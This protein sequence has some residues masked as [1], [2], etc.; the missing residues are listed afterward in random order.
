M[1]IPYHKFNF[2]GEKTK[3]HLSHGAAQ[4]HLLSSTFFFHVVHCV[5][6]AMNLSVHLKCQYDSLKRFCGDLFV[7]YISYM[8]FCRSCMMTYAAVMTGSSNSLWNAHE[9]LLND[10][11]TF[12]SWR[13]NV[14][15]CPH[16]AA[17]LDVCVR[18]IS[19]PSSKVRSAVETQARPWGTVPKSTVPKRTVP[20]S[21]NE[22]KN[23]IQKHHRAR[24]RRNCL[25]SRGTAPLLC[26]GEELTCTCRSLPLVAWHWNQHSEPWGD[27]RLHYYEEQTALQQT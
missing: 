11:V 27:T 4:M 13:K 8:Y 25:T 7:T 19:H 16:G 15:D 24:C 21:G 12:F 22:A 9:I 10:V 26:G 14:A 23:S 18:Q 20:L 2:T 6:Q 5:S 3:D 1:L 17:A